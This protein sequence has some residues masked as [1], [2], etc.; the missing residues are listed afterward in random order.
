MP[1]VQRKVAEEL[2]AVYP[3]SEIPNSA[4]LGVLDLFKAPMQ[5]AA[6]TTMP[7]RVRDLPLTA[8]CPISQPG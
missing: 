4:G 1:K 6:H 7:N 2:R 3:R 5:T 8:A